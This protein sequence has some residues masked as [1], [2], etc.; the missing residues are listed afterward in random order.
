MRVSS[1]LQ[2]TFFAFVA[3]AWSS[4][5][6]MTTIDREFSGSG[7]KMPCS[8]LASPSAHSSTDMTFINEHTL[9]VLTLS[10]IINEIIRE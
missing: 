3:T 8:V 5:R 1:I 2:N 7:Y 9:I 6:R 10:T 4:D